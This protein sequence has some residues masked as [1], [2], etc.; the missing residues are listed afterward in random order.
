[1]ANAP[2]PAPLPGPDEALAML[3]EGNAAFLRGENNLG[4]VKAGDLDDLQG[5]QHP[6][7]TIVGCADSRTPP[8]ILFNQGFGRLFSIRVAGNT[9][10]RRGLA[11]I[12][13]AVKHLHC[14]LV[15]VMGHTGCGAVAAAEAIVDG[16]A[17][18]DPSLE[19]MIV[20]IIPAVLDARRS[21][22]AD[23]ALRAVEENARRVA[24]KL[25]TADTSLADAIK[26]GKLKVVAAVKQMHSGEVRF[27][28]MSPS[29]APSAGAHAGELEPA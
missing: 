9:V 16:K 7:A 29:P 5:G 10:D 15:V 13:Y 12:V 19:E 23:M 24:E 6:I 25:V 28:E 14:P 17:Q 3:L 27:L 4:H 20:P 11:S 22:A 8:T 2:A 26:A 21:G 18:M 1:M